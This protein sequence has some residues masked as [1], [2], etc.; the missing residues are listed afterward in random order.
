M[1][2]KELVMTAIRNGKTPRTPYVPFV[3]VHAGYLIDKTAEEFLKSPELMK[4]G[5]QKAIDI[6]K[7]DG[8]PVIFDLQLE[9]EVLGCDLIW[10]KENPPSVSSHVLTGDKWIEDLPEFTPEGGRIPDILEVTRAVRE[11]NP[12]IALYGLIAGPFTLSLHLLGPDIFMQMYDNP[13]KVM[14]IMAY[15]EGIGE[16]MTQAYHDAGCDII[17]VVDPMTSQIGPEDF[18]RF[19]TPS[20]KKLFSYIRKRG[21]VSSFFVCGHAQKNIEAMCLCKPDNV[22]IDEN[23]PLDYVRDTAKK[24]GVS[25][26]GNMKLT[27]VMLFGTEQD[28]LRHAAECISVGGTDGFILAPGCDIPYSVPKENIIA[29]SEMVKDEYKQQV[30]ME[31]IGT[32]TVAESDLDL[33]EYGGTN[34]IQV[35]IIT[36]D[37]EAC[38]PCQ[39]MVES[40]REIAPEFEGV[41]DW[42]EHKIKTKE[43]IE[44]MT[45]LKVEKVP[46]ICIDGKVA[47]ISHIPKKQDLINAIYRRMVE[48]AKERM[49]STRSKIILLDDGSPEADTM[50]E[51]ISKAQR[52]LGSEIQIVKIDAEKARNVYHIKKMP[53]V[54]TVQ[55]ELR[56]V[57]KVVDK[58]VIKE[59]I[60]AIM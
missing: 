12:D 53:A 9:A 16:T 47:F 30:A 23:I 10:G 49:H 15:C 52:E 17:A 37:S 48:R 20:S 43:A 36:L 45:A 19:V 21:A 14:D 41:V 26:G 32:Q 6:Y 57:G 22:S 39:Y 7:P 38:A 60:K 18:T 5:I 33:S 2:G 59:W 46:T 24:N 31:L 4:Q 58:E 40:V 29:V 13:D 27:T 55:E 51:N 54:I 42:N 35:D 11:K 3:G 25:F 44:L 28:N 1:T 8:M 56:S 50:F 34:K